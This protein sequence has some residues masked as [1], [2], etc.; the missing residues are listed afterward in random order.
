[1]TERGRQS[2]PEPREYG[3]ATTDPLG[4]TGWNEKA[5]LPKHHN[6]PCDQRHGPRAACNSNAKDD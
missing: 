2:W 3:Q 6:Q 5:H 1:M 4:R